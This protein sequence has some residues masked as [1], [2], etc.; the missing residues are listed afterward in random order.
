MIARTFVQNTKI[1]LFDE[2]TSTFDTK[3]KESI[4]KIIQNRKDKYT[5]LII[6][7][8]L[9]T[10][11]NADKIMIVEDGKNTENG[12][13][14]ELLKNSKRYQKLYEAQF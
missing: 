12:T 3:T 7:H 13:H 2:A 6:A 10:I 5:I 8:R 11:V 14:S 4:Q 1:I 9:S